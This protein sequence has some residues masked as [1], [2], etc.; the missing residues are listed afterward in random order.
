MKVFLYQSVSSFLSWKQIHK[1]LSI[2]KLAKRSDVKV[3]RLLF[4][5]YIKIK[6]EEC[7]VNAEIRRE[8]KILK[9]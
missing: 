7:H 9:I 1:K 4:L 5:L 2:T 6:W 3:G 8:R